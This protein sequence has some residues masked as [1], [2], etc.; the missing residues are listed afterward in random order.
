MFFITRM[1][2]SSAENRKSLTRSLNNYECYIAVQ[3][4][5]EIENLTKEG[6]TVKIRL[7]NQEE[8]KATV[9]K[10]KEDKGDFLVIFKITDGVENLINY[11]KIS[12]DIIWWSYEGLMTPKTAILYEDG[13]SYVVRNRNGEF[14]KVLV[15]IVKENDKYCIIDNY[16]SEDLSQMGLETEEI[17]NIKKI[18]LYDE[19]VVN[20]EIE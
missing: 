1:E 13:L 4:G 2:S 6:E 10:I 17:K 3:F 15:K 5:K 8:I 7:A 12:L 19:I 9:Y 18:K 14:E 20:P 11:R 16:D